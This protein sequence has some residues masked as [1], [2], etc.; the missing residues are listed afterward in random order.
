MDWSTF[1]FI[2]YPLPIVLIDGSDIRS[3]I[4]EYSNLLNDPPDSDN[5]NRSSSRGRKYPGCL[6][7]P[8]DTI[9]IVDNI[10]TRFGIQYINKGII[11]DFYEFNRKVSNRR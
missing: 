6:V 4:N 2:S 3:D 7:V 10:W 1:S 11:G 5:G 9:R 8:M